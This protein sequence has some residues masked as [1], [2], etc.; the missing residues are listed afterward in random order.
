MSRLQKYLLVEDNSEEI[1]HGSNGR[2]VD[3]TSDKFDELLEKNCTHYF[4][5]DGTKL[6]RGILKTTQGRFK[7]IDPSKFTRKSQYTYN[8]YMLVMELSKKW[9]KYPKLSNS[10]IATSSNSDAVTWGDVYEVIP[11][12]NAKLVVTAKE[13]LWSS[14]PDHLDVFSHVLRNIFNVTDVSIETDET[15]ITKFFDACVSVDNKL[16]KNKS[17]LEGITD[18][19]HN[20]YHVIII[21]GLRKGQPLFNILEEILKPDGVVELNKAGDDLPHKREIWTNSPCLLK[22]W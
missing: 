11:Y 14:F 20:I 15:S 18:D 22:L 13:H 8:W 2:S 16:K 17:I 21:N 5:R 7:F 6:Y 3:I 1:E 9:N 4:E 19:K 12:D 10:I